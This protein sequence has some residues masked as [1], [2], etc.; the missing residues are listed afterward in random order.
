MPPGEAVAPDIGGLSSGEFGELDPRVS[1]PL[2]EVDGE[3]GD[4]VRGER[5]GVRACP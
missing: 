5:E 4:G 1:K 2:E 3:R